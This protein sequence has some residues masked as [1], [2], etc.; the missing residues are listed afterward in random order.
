VRAASG[1]HAGK[2]RPV[3]A[4]CSASVTYR[5][6]RKGGYVFYARA[7]AAGG[8]D[9]AAVTRAFTVR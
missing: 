9:S 8:V 1:K 3:Y 6:L 2:P 5:H 4:R 7:V